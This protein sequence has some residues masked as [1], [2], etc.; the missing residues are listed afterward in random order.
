MKI[1]E[2]QN[3]CFAD[4]RSGELY[5]ELVKTDGKR[6][7]LEKVVVRINNPCKIKKKKIILTN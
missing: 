1:L 4:F 2:N 7:F 5:R 3:P 6:G